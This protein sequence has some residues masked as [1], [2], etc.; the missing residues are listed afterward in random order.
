VCSCQAVRRRAQAP[1]PD[2]SFVPYLQDLS[3]AIEAHD[4]ARAKLP[5]ETYASQ[6]EAGILSRSAVERIKQ[7][8]HAQLVLGAAAAERAGP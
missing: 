7:Q 6:S 4:A 2:H 1:H 8:L 3:S 5:A